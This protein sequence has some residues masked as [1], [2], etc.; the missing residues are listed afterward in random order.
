LLRAAQEKP[1]ALKSLRIR[2]NYLAFQA[3]IALGALV[4]GSALEELDAGV[5]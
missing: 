5:V 1:L 4:A 3:G 2:A